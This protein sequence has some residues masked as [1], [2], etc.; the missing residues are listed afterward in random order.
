MTIQD[1]IEKT[2][3][4]IQELNIDLNDELVKRFYSEII[5]I[6][7][8]AKNC[9]HNRNIENKTLI[10]EIRNKAGVLFN[11]T[12]PLKNKFGEQ[13]NK[14]FFHLFQL[15]RLIEISIYG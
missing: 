6:W 4:E 5:D 1:L 11:F 14:V 8:T 9:Y 3:N 12:Y 7:E 2:K 13:I 15:S 10:F